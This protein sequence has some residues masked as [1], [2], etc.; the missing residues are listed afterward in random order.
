[1]LQRVP[2]PELCTLHVRSNYHALIEKCVRALRLVTNVNRILCSIFAARVQV[3][4]AAPQF[5]AAAVAGGAI[6][7][8][9]LA[10]FMGK[11][12]VFFFYPKVRAASWLQCSR[13]V[14]RV[15]IELCSHRSYGTR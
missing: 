14:G 7:K 10:D 13:V 2:C 9:S 12:V 1:V 5:T 6:T 15:V 4:K 11:W 3:G 8:L